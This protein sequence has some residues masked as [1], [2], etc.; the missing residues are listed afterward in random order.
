MECFVMPKFF[1]CCFGAKWLSPKDLS[2]DLATFNEK[3]IV[4]LI[5]CFPKQVDQSYVESWEGGCNVLRSDDSQKELMLVMQNLLNL[6]WCLDSKDEGRFDQLMQLFLSSSQYLTESGRVE[7]VNEFGDEKKAIIE[8]GRQPQ[9]KNKQQARLYLLQLRI[10]KGFTDCDQFKLNTLKMLHRSIS[11]ISLGGIRFIDDFIN[12][13]RK[14][15]TEQSETMCRVKNSEIY[16]KLGLSGIHLVKLH[17]NSIKLVSDLLREDIVTSL[18]YRLLLADGSGC[19]A[20]TYC[21]DLIKMAVKECRGKYKQ[22]F[23]A[24]ANVAVAISPKK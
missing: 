19:L 7:V 4:K 11:N 22:H 24:S 16:T 8:S 20:N 12:M 23:I 15:N 18:T 14:C 2:I 21:L 17:E 3:K 9:D 10:W 5:K 1:P 13:M 6:M